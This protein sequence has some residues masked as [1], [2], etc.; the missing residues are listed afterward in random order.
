MASSSK[1][2]SEF[3]GNPLGGTPGKSNGMIHSK[4]PGGSLISPFPQD[5]V[6]GVDLP[7]AHTEGAG[8]WGGSD[9]NLA[10]SLKGASAV[11][12]HGDRGGQKFGKG[13]RKL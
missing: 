8:K 10:H 6:H 7:G 11:Q 1:E 12:D 5:N 9:T 4:V 13:E 3:T 2:H